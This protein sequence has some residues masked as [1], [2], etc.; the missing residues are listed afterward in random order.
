MNSNWQEVLRRIQRRLSEFVE[1]RKRRGGGVTP[2]IQASAGSFAALAVAMARRLAD[3]LRLPQL[4]GH[5]A[6]GAALGV[7]DIRSMEDRFAEL[8]A[9]RAE[10]ADSDDV[11]VCTRF[12]TALQELSSAML[13][14]LAADLREAEQQGNVGRA[15][16]VRDRIRALLDDPFETIQQWQPPPD[17]TR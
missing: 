12:L 10:A 15:A 4:R 7:P 1:V 3:Q 2:S 11:H 8:D 16:Q 5:Q 6:R 13:R 17:A 14:E 9:L